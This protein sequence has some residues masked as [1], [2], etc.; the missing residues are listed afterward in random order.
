MGKE[1]GFNENKM[2]VKLL[3]VVVS[4]ALT[5][6]SSSILV[7]NVSAAKNLNSSKS[8]I[9]RVTGNSLEPV[10][11]KINQLKEDPAVKSIRIDCIVKTNPFQII[12]TVTWVRTQSGGLG[13][14]GTTTTTRGNSNGETINQNK[15]K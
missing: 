9:Y 6:V 13:T 4:L 11:A 1:Q 10:Q 12:C 15:S 8:N 5:I 3:A 7:A 2:R 14:E